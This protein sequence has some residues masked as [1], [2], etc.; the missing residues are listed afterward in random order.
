VL[1]RFTDMYSSPD[2]DGFFDGA[3]GY[4]YLSLEKFIGMSPF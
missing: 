4:G 2:E 3:R 1:Q